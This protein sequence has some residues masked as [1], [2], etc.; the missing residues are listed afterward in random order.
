MHDIKIRAYYSNFRLFGSSFN[1]YKILRKL[2]PLSLSSEAASPATASYSDFMLFFFFFRCW[3]SGLAAWHRMCSAASVVLANA[4]RL[5]LLFPSYKQIAM[6]SLHSLIFI[7]NG[8]YR[9]QAENEKSANTSKF[10]QFG[11][12]FASPLLLLLLLFFSDH[13]FVGSSFVFV[14][15][16]VHCFHSR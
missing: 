2:F 16:C 3:F 5:N 7:S 12:H 11:V 1:T 9:R 10:S 8:D 14:A 6:S 15:F 13:K 4:F